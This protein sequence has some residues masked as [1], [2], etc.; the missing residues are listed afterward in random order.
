MAVLCE[1][2]GRNVLFERFSLGFLLWAFDRFSYSSSRKRHGRIGPWAGL[3]RMQRTHGFGNLPAGCP[4]GCP[5]RESAEKRRNS[6]NKREK[7]AVTF[8]AIGRLAAMLA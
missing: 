7:R 3:A 5:C 8:R 4:V 1:R 2:F 6:T